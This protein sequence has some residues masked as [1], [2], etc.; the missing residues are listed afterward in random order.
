M[1]GAVVRHA[2]ANWRG[3]QRH[4]TFRRPRI[5][6]P[7]KLL[8]FFLFA[9]AGSITPGP[10]NMISTAS[11]AAFGFARTVPQM[12]GVSIGYPLMI[13]ALGL[14]FGEIFRQFPWL[15]EVLRYAGAAFLL[16]LAWRIAQASGPE[17]TEAS[18]PLTLFEAALFQWINPKAWTLAVGTVATFTTPGLL[19]GAF[20]T[21]ISII[22]VLSGA[23]AFASLVVWCIFGAMIAG[24]LADERKRRIFQL[25]LA[26]LL[27]ASVV[28][29][30]I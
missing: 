20:L 29:L 4:A 8:P 22:A 21:E 9:L 10:N 27:A 11:G 13:V 30:L 26:G 16:Y 1:R 23:I 6:L 3:A 2:P 5:A 19:F 12:L 7:E 28:F 24:A 15:H 25:S 14:G 18:R 17:R